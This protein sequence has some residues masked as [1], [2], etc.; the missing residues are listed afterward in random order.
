MEILSRAGAVDILHRLSTGGARFRELNEAVRNSRT[1]TRR[2]NEL[3]AGGLIRR[4]GLEYRITEKDFDNLLGTVEAWKSA[5]QE[6]ARIRHGWLRI[7]LKRLTFFEGVWWRS[8]FPRRLQFL[9]EDSFKPGE[10]DVDLLYIVEDDSKEVWRREASIFKEFK[11][12]WEY[13][14]CDYWFKM[15]GFYD[16][17]EVTTA[18][19]RRG[20]AARFQPVYLD[21]IFHKAVLYDKDGFFQ[22]LMEELRRALIALGTVRV[23]CP[24]G[25]YFWVLKPDAVFGE[26]ISIGVG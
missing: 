25:T 26:S 9:C 17:P 1:L 2:L 14:A 6:L 7:S 3:S 4:A 19:F 11:S 13:R 15:R 8:D 12:T 21:M 10:S 23:E 22:R 16:Y 24:D 20:Y 18:S 5:G